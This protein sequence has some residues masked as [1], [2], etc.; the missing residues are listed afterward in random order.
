MYSMWKRLF[1]VVTILLVSSSAFG[2]YFWYQLN[3]TK[4]QLADTKVQLDNT[5]VELDT[6]RAQLTDTKTL[7]DTT[8]VELDAAKAQLTDTKTLLDT[9][10][11]QLVDTEAKLGTTK[12]QLDVTKTQLGMTA[13]QLETEKNKNN[14]ML[15]QYGDFK[16]QIGVRLALKPG[17][18]QSFITPN[19]SSVSAKVLEITGGYSEDINEYWRDCER[20]YQWIVNNIAYSYDSYIPIL[21]ETIS[22]ELIWRQEY[23]RTPEETIGDETG[24][25]EDMALLLASMLRSYNEG[26]YQVWVLVIR[27]SVPEV[28][29]HVAMAFPVQDSKL[30][31][32]D[33][34]G[35]YHTGQYES[36][37]SESVSIAVNNWLSHWQSE[38]PSAE[39]VE[40][41]SEDIYKEFSSTAEFITWAQE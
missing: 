37:Q 9:T 17:N 21:P 8:L 2:G 40:V 5:L 7:L 22:G 29:G 31:I 39:I 33:P 24:D 11:I 41:F 3:V 26:E 20:L 23:W 35:N 12:T 27:S 10:Q 28:K 6:T 25:C 18:K 14:Q 19:N 36:L 4:N 13:T 16:Q 15:N 1:I 38:M 34:A 30:T 32:L